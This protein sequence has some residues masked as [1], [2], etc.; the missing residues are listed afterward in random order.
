MPTQMFRSRISPLDKIA[1]G[2]ANHDTLLYGIDKIAP[3]VPS[4]MMLWI[5]FAPV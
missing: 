3:G 1:P 4:G 2:T 5:S